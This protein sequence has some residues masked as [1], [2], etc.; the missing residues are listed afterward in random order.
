MRSANHVSKGAKIA[1]EQH[2]FNGSE[3]KCNFVAPAEN[4]VIAKLHRLL[5]TQDA[6][7]SQLTPFQTLDVLCILLG[8]YKFILAATHEL[9]QIVQELRN[10]R[11]SHKIVQLEFGDPLSEEDP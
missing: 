6:W 10:V 9:Q 7:N 2:F 4:L 5:G 8:G 3:Y 1:F 11:C